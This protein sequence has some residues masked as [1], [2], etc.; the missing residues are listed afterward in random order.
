MVGA[1]AECV[2][3]LLLSS[4]SRNINHVLPQAC[5]W[6]NLN[7]GACIIDCC[8]AV[9][10]VVVVW[11]HAWRR[12][13]RASKGTSWLLLCRHLVESATQ[14]WAAAATVVWS[15]S[16]HVLHLVAVNTQVGVG[17]QGWG[18]RAHKWR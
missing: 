12:L 1:S 16:C 9:L 5:I 7:A 13:L 4:S 15:N 8:L 2:V 10:S 11:C 3:V 18:K 14:C 6:V 17:V